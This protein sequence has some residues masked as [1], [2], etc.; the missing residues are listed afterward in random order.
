MD[1][2]KQFRDYNYE[3]SK[4]GSV[5]NLKTCRILKQRV[6][7][8]YGYVLVDIQ[9]NK[10]NKTFKVHRLVAETFL[11]EKD[12][13]YQVDH[14]NRVRHDNR[15]ENLRWVTPSENNANRGNISKDII[16]E[17]IEAYKNNKTIDEIYLMY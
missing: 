9:I 16:F 8:N 10:T 1:E 13:N 15:L 7:K 11:G 4:N 5:R 3:V 2:W 12:G 17:I 14:I 6:D